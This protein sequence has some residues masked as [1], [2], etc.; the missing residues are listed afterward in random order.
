M[1]SQVHRRTAL[2]T[3]LA[4]AAAAA[5][6]AAQQAVGVGVVEG[7]VREAGTGRPLEGV[8]IGVTG[9]N[10]G[11]VTNGRGAFRIQDVPART[12]ELRVRLVGYSPVTRSVV[13]TSGQVKTADFDLQ[14]SALQLEAVVTTGTG[15]AVEVKK[16]GN[17]IGTIEP[18]K[19]APINTPSELLQ[20]KEPGLV[21]LPSSGMTGE[22]ARIRIRG[23]ASLSQSNEPIVFVDGVRVNSSGDFSFNIGAGGGGSPSRLD[24][25]DPVT[26]DRIEVLKGAA[27]ATLY[28]TEASNG[29]IQIFTKKGTSGPPRWDL[30]VA[31]DAIKYPTNRLEEN[32]GYATRAGQADSL[33]K[34]WGR[35]ITPFKPFSQPMVADLFETGKASTVAASLT[36]GNSALTYFASGRYYAE[37]GPW[38]GTRTGTTTAADK[39]TRA[40]GTLNVN[41]LPTSKTRLA[42]R[43]AY[44]NSRLET[45]NNSNNIFSPITQA[46][47]G[48]PDLANCR[49]SDPDG[50]DPD[51]GVLSPGRCKSAGNAYGV[52]GTFG[53]PNELQG[54][55]TKQGVDR[56]IAGLDFQYTPISE[57]NFTGTFG[58]DYTSS[59]NSS[60]QEFLYNVDH[61]TAN[62]TAG[63]K[64]VQDRNDREITLDGKMNWSRNFTTRISSSLV[65]GAQGFISRITQPG[66]FSHNFPGPGIAVASAGEEPVVYD[67][68]EET[69]NGGFFAQEQLGWA[70]WVFATVGARYDYASTFGENAGGVLYPKISLSIVPTSHPSWNIPVLSS[71]RIRAA[72]GQSGRQPGAFDKLTTFQALNGTS[73]SG[74]APF[75]LGNPNLDPEVSTELEAGFEAG[76]WADRVGLQ[77]TYWDRVVDDL[78]VE[79]QY[80]LSGGFQTRQLSNIGQM[81]AHGVELSLR[82]LVVNRPTMNIDLFAN[83]AYLFQKITSLGGAAE[84]KVSGSYPRYRNF[85]REGYDPGHLFGAKLMQP[86]R[87]GQTAGCLQAGQLPYDLDGDG[88]ADSEADVRSF[89]STPTSLGDLFNGN[90][91]LLENGLN[92]DLG[93]PTPDWT[94]AWGGTFT[95]FRNWRVYTLFEYKGGN[96]TY[97]CLTCGFRNASTRA[98][99]SSATARVG[100]I[101]QD[102]AS[103]AD[104]RLAAAKEWVYELAA[105]TPYDGLNQNSPAD[106]TR[107][108]ELSLTYTASPNVAAKIRARELS[109]TLSGRNLA[110]WTKY[111]GTDPEVNAIGRTLGGGRDSNYLDAVDAFNL[112]LPRRVGLSV[113]LGY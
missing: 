1:V 36:G 24:D 45:P 20:G 25:I 70:D 75:N 96:Y 113:R 56:Y 50:T 81:K 8:Q 59:Q 47:F 26:I 58:V 77:A 49:N 97:T 74:L 57:L 94:G 79:K 21:G 76:F 29:V 90:V 7:T 102:P 107:W 5:R 18:P 112:P 44:T 43:A 84:L 4:F 17:T 98:R 87:S 88:E 69:V 37:D 83:G 42:G 51:L 13:V 93:K 33:S 19:Y 38:A 65:V 11:T 64:T 46:L 27:A 105:L 10:I 2:V 68:I 16:L 55:L 85:L 62:D 14:Q 99:N 41:M 92:S 80:P 103:T 109:I 30:N 86:C 66:G 35:T 67:R 82:G 23:N 104:Q 3:A 72:Y 39:S 22:G 40:Q 9:A 73:G 89:L 12:V 106:F 95:F 111:V 60:F 101:L 110:L 91:I 54:I 15:G 48:K 32:W 31:Q 63:A 108:R 53:T 34:F 52:Q 28:G 100:A 78:L 61:I 71:F 6:L